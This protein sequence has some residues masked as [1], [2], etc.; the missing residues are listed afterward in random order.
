M[1]GAAISIKYYY[2]VFSVLDWANALIRLFIAVEVEDANVLKRIITFRDQVV[3]C[4]RGRGVKAVEDE[5][6]HLTI[7]FI[8]EVPEA[9]LP[10]IEK[11]LDLCASVKKFK[12]IVKGVGA[13]PSLSRPRV[14]W[15]GVEEGADQFRQLRKILDNCLKDIV[16]P[17]KHEFTPHITIARVK[18][19]ID[20]ECLASLISENQDLVFGEY[21]VTTVKLKRSIL[22]PQGP[23]YIDLKSVKLGD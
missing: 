13:F 6:I 5:N 8:G 21:T 15:V 7:R 14:I 12:V 3:A 10:S 16:S 2:R 9:L 20:R 22:R 11:C 1:E 17:D 19:S 18:G 23:L 4:A